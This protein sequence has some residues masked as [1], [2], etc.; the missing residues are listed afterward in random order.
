MTQAMAAYHL[1]LVEDN[2]ADVRLVKEAVRTF[3]VPVRTTV[4]Q[5]VSAA[6]DFFGPRGAGQQDPPDLVLLDLH[7]GIDHG[8]LVL[9][10]LKTGERTRHIPLIVL[11]GTTNPREV[12]EVYQAHANCFI[13]K[14][15]DVVGYL[16][17]LRG[18][19]T[20]W[21]ETAGRRRAALQPS[22][23]G[24][25]LPLSREVSDEPSHAGP[26]RR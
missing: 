16:A 4:I 5:D 6:L 3:P 15:S 18:M 19:M 12:Q 25:P 26:D 23:S 11:S 7:L 8:S 13:E 21:F 9:Q 22:A 10:Y 24:R 2:A 17:T 20:F 14:S 1:L